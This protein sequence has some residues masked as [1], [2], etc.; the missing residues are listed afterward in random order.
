MIYLKSFSVPTQK[1]EEEYYEVC[2]IQGKVCSMNYP[3]RILSS[4]DFG[5]R[6][7]FSEV[8]IFHGGNGTGKSTLIK[9]IAAKL[10]IYSEAQVV[11]DSMNR[12]IELCDE[13]SFSPKVQYDRVKRDFNSIYDIHRIAQ[14]LTSDD[15]FN[16]ILSKRKEN[17]CYDMRQGMLVEE[18]KNCKNY[19]ITSVDFESEK[20]VAEYSR[21]HSVASKRR[22]QFLKEVL[23]DRCAEYSNGESSLRFFAERITPGHLY[24]LDEPENSL[25]AA[26]QLELA[27]LIILFTQRHACQFIIATHSPFLFAIQGA[28]IYDLDCTPVEVRCWWDLESVQTYRTFFQLHEHVF[29]QNVKYESGA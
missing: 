17:Q 12:Y 19:K 26:M 9:V 21:I 4:L 27:K 13:F 25:S 16:S 20:A 15:V 7:N 28:K 22:S 29:Q 5:G 6:I 10:G 23:G 8:T 11:S 2:R 3:F 24:L 18:W 14:Q 1:E